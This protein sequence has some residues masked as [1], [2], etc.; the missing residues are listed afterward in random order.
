VGGGGT[1]VWAQVVI[2]LSPVGGATM[3]GGCEGTGMWAQVISLHTMC[4][5]RGAT[6]KGACE[7]V[8]LLATPLTQAKGSGVRAYDGSFR[9][10]QNLGDHKQYTTVLKRVVVHY[11]QTPDPSGCGQQARLMR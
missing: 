10:P 7:G 5:V 2:S 1:G 6:G 4:P 11:V 8:V 3:L 9:F